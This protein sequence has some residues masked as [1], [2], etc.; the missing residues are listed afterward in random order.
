MKTEPIV[1][2][3]TYAA[4]VAKVWKALTDKNDMKQ[5]YFDLSD[6]KPEVGFEFTFI[7]TDGKKSFLHLCK[8][9]EV[10][11][12]R[13][14]KHSWRYDGVP[15]DSFVTW[16]LFEEG[17]NR[18]RVK[19]TH[20]GLESFPQDTTDYAKQNFI[21]GW[22]AIVGT[23]LLE[24]VEVSDIVKAIEINVTPEHLWKLLVSVEAVTQWAEA[25]SGGTEVE[26]DFKKGSAIVWRDGTGAIG[27]SGFISAREDGALLEFTYPDDT[28]VNA[29]NPYKE[30]FTISAHNGKSTLKIEAGP[31][32]KKYVKI[33]DPKWDEALVKIRAM[34]VR[35]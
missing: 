35:R 7:G 21:K 14:L 8:I 11:P 17:K 29:S 31:L 25:F 13:K 1:M 34:A 5:W 15:G 20:E 26:S 22:T 32:P 33:H 16:E 3:R 10:I 27:A 28:E 24:Y 23:E 2:E 9:I 12:Q 18:T 4:P 19:L 30:R 6:F